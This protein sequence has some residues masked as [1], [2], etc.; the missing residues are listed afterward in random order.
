MEK[1][2]KLI[3]GALAAVAVIGGLGASGYYHHSHFNKN[4]TING[5]KVGGLTSE[6]AYQKLASQK[7]SNDVYLNGKK[8]TREPAP[9]LATPAPTRPR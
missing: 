4:V 6:A 7:R 9:R 1:T 5:V 3:W 8:S 2:Q